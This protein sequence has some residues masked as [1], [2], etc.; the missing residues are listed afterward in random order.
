MFTTAGTQ[1]KLA[2]YYPNGLTEAQRY[3]RIVGSPE[4]VAAYYQS[5]V[6]AGVQHFVCQSQDAADVETF[7][8]LAEEVAPRVAIR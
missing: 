7:R 6:D 1:A 5:M 4:Q 3:S 8:L 2:R